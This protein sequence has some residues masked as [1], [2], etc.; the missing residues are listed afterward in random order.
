MTERNLHLWHPFT[1]EGADPPP[2]HAVR[3]EGVFLEMRDGRRILDAISSWWVNL[4]GHAHPAIAA[5]I[6]KQAARLEHVL[7]AGFSHEPAEE[8]AARLGKIVPAPLRHIF[9]SDDG[10]T[11]VEVALKLAVQF[12]S[13][14][15]RPEKHGI[16][17]LEHAYHGDTVG[18]MS[19]SDDSPFTSA[20]DSLRIPVLRTHS[21]SCAHC[22]VGLTRATCHIECL[23]KLERL[24]ME[25]GYEIAAVIVE[26]LL[27]GAG[28]MIVHPEEFLSGVRRLTAAHDV[29]L[30]ADEVLTGFGRTGRM[31][32][33]ERAGVAPDI[34]CVA[35]GITGGFLPLAATITTDRVHD[36]FTGTDRSRAFYHGHSYTANPI[37]CAAANA[38]L[39]IFDSE[40]VFERIAAIERVHAA[41]LPAFAAHPGVSDVRH[42]GTVAA[43]EL[44]V[45]DAGYL[46]SL[47]PRLYEYFLSR[48]VL[49]RPLGNVVYILPP[50]VITQEQLNFVYD[51]I[52]DSLPLVSRL[53]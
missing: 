38:N 10:S 8:L 12:W 15:G 2:L 39:Q 52:K 31:F 36:A 40:P 47:R 3:G 7:F 48:G 46:S 45:P 22:P 6:A 25:R 53:A 11:A 17:A 33:C 20:F 35:K 30:I 51:V 18:A 23:N 24:L 1:H 32:A 9:F 27:Q 49:L 44:K 4:H 43:I 42:I 28:G 13:N 37:A 50:Y 21:A 16:V 41:R 26:P 34:L 5:A 29:L 19:V 14:C